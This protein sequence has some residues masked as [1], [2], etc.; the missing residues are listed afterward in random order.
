MHKKRKRQKKVI[1]GLGP[2]VQTQPYKGIDSFYVPSPVIFF[3]NGLFYLRGSCAGVYF[4]G[5]K[6]DEFSWGLSI[7]AQPRIYSYN[8]EDSEYLTGMD[9]RETTFERGLAFSAIYKDM[10]IQSMLLTHML[11]LF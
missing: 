6:D 10:Y 1:I 5:N 4:L 3:D 8:P 11:V 9:T 2:Y 7:T